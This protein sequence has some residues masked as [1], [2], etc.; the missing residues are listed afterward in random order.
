[1]IIPAAG[2]AKLPDGIIMANGESASHGGVTVE[3]IPAYDII[4]GEPSHPK[5]KSNGYVITI[6]GK[7][8]YIAGVTECVPEV[9]ALKN[10]DV[11]FVPLNVPLGRMTPAAAAACVVLI[12]PKIVY[13]YHSDQILAARLANPRA[14]SEGPADGL[15]V[16]QS[17]QA[18]KDALRGQP[19]EVRDGHWYPTPVPHATGPIPVTGD[20]YPFGAADH[21]R[22]PEDLRQVGF[23]EEEFLVSGRANV[24]DW[25]RPGPAVVRTALVPYTTR[26]IVR[27][28]ASRARFSGNVIVEML[29]PSNLFDLNLAWAISHKQIVRNGDAWVGITAKPVS[30]ATL[31]SFNPTRYAT[32]V[33]GEPVASRRPG[34]LCDRRHATARERRRTGWCGI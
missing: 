15:T 24:Y 25:P 19:I 28:P 5:G 27:R 16:A 29:N 12:A 6:G 26:V 2:K 11:A 20:S 3:A 31:K 10:I 23:V 9:R 1:M 13:A 32:S 4:Q 8:I 21:E 7:R 34:Q 22:V 14:T 30:I 33:L 17:L 18:F